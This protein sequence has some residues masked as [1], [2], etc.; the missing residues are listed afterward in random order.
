MPI[1]QMSFVIATP[2]GV[3]RLYLSCRNGMRA[4]IDSS[5]PKKPMSAGRDSEWT[6]RDW[7]GV[8]SFDVGRR[9]P[10]V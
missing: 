6:R 3:G 8:N 7:A 4:Y 1:I 2:P 10:P 9:N 5:A